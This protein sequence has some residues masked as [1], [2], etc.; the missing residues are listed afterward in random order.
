MHKINNYNIFKYI[1][2]YFLDKRTQQKRLPK[3]IHTSMNDDKRVGDHL[4]LSE[5]ADYRGPY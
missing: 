2:K 3:D 1:Y 5:T 4:K